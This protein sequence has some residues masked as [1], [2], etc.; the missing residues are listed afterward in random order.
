MIRAL[1]A[2]IVL[3]V[4]AC[5]SAP[6]AALKLLGQALSSHLPPRRRCSVD[7]LDVHGAETED[8]DHGRVIL[9]WQNPIVMRGASRAFHISARPNGHGV[10]RRELASDA[11]AGGAAQM[12]VAEPGVNPTVLA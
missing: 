11:V 9:A 5:A 2:A 8:G 10:V 6:A 1:G 7:Q 12:Q 3:G 4:S